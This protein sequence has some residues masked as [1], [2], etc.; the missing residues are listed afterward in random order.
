MAGRL[1]RR[2]SGF[3]MAISGVNR[4][5]LSGLA[6]DARVLGAN[7]RAARYSRALD[8]VLCP[9]LTGEGI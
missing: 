3:C 7:E 1:L 8:V 2:P 9:K 4:R 5:I 6:N